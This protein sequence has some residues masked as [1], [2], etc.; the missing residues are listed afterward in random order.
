MH[1]KDRKRVEAM[2]GESGD[3]GADEMSGMRGIGCEGE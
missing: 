3:D 1:G 2:D